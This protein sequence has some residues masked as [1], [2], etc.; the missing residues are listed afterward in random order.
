MSQENKELVRGWFEAYSRHDVDAVAEMMAPDVI[1]N[2]STNQGRDGVRAELDYWYSAFPDVSV[3]IEDLIEEGDRVVARLTAS[4][5]HRGEFMGAPPTGK[6]I[7]AQEIDVFRLENGLIAEVWAAPD[8]FGLLTQ[9]GL[10]SA[11]EPA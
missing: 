3:V 11:E 8:I 10:L 2:S 4:G 5:T 7:T 1:N 6:Q 9:L